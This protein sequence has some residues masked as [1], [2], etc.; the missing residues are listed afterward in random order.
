M[1][2]WF[3]DSLL[4]GSY[5]KD[6]LHDMSAV[7][8]AAFILDGDNEVIAQPLD[9]L[10][11]NY[12]TRHVV[13]AGL[14]PGSSE[15][16]FHLN[17]GLETT[18]TGWDIDPQGLV[19]ILSQVQRDYPA[20]P[21]YL[22]ENGA[23]FDDVAV[24]GVVHD[25]NRIEFL[26]SHLASL[27]DDAGQGD[28]HPRLLRVV[29]ARQLRVVRGLRQALRHRARRLRDAEAYA[30]GQRALVRRPHQAPPSRDTGSHEPRQRRG[31]ANPRAGRGPGGGRVAALLR[32]S[33]T[34]RRRSAPAPARWS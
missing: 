17:N 13:G 20:L 5:P 14:W 29:A 15:V 7:T 4:K 23:A 10:G 11:V 34:D 19:D 33:S 30:Q 18:D 31:A 12:Y 8:D 1:N 28:G 24:D 2:R 22:T 16:R 32:A 6:V 27:A 25:A 26:E 3:L 21:I 9:F